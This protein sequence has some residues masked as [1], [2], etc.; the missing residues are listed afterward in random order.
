MRAMG[1][2]L[3]RQLRARPLAVCALCFLGGVVLAQASRLSFRTALAA[4]AA[5]FG[6]TRLLRPPMRRSVSATLLVGIALL[7]GILRAQ[8]AMDAVPRVYTQYNK[9]MVGRV[10]SEPFTHPTSGRVISKFR[11]ETLGG[12]PSKLCVRL[13]LRGDEAPL[14][15][16]AYG[17]RLSLTGHIW[18]NDP[19][20]NPHEFDFGAF[21]RRDGM[22]AMATAKIEDV[23]VVET[24]VD[25]QTHVIAARDALSRRIDALFPAH[26]PL[27][28]A[29]LLGDR[30][31]LS[32]EQREAFRD[33]GTAHLISISGLHVTVLAGALAALLGLFMNRR[34]A[35]VAAAV[36]LVPYGAVIGFPPAFV[37]AL[38]MFGVY[39]LAPV[40]GLP[41]DGVTRLGAA[42]LATLLLRP[43][44]ATDAGFVLSYSAAAGLILLAPPLERLLRLDRLRERIPPR[45]RPWRQLH[46]RVPLAIGGVLVAS[47]AAQLAILPAVVAFFGVQ[48]LLALPFNLVCVPLC[49]MGYLLALAAMVL[50]FAAMPV[51]RAAAQAAGALFGPMLSVTRLS[52][53]LPLATVRVGRYPALLALLHGAIAVAASDL[54]LLKPRLRRALPLALVL[55]AGLSSLVAFARNWNFRIVFLDADQADCAV[56]TTRGHTWLVDAGDTYSPA[57]DYLSAT[58]L[59]LDGVFLSHPHQDH[60]GGLMDVLT[61]FTPKAVYVPA[62]WFGAEGVPD[63]V[64]EGIGLARERGI[65]IVEL[66]AGDE[67]A[68]SDE[69]VLRVYNPAPGAVV[70]DVNDLST[71]ALISVRGHGALFT[72]DLT[73]DGE[74]RQLPDADVLKVAHHGADNATSARFLR[75]TTPEI[76]VV[77][78]GENSFGHPAR[79]TLER[80]EAVG[81]RT[82][83]TRDC[84]AVTL[85]LCRDEW[86]VK[87]F[88]EA[89]R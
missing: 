43:L 71:L 7:A 50:S 39:S 75:A 36:L 73:A 61:A 53:Q 76:A 9:P 57:A 74:P 67:I 88:L 45:A 63:A 18:A 68:L 62:G 55:V 19:V 23:A 16:I 32:E 22:A 15:D 65:E 10:V 51:A 3:A 58:A 66:A 17:Q 52:A 12:A 86:Q 85:R 31:Q 29:L 13:Y 89:S 35:S 56:V 80:L 20:T 26:A 8:L 5:F 21:L 44:A 77:S 30:S 49:L 42:L 72:G 41:S 83:L 70:E 4:F 54:S 14:S 2:F 64:T 6:A 59:S 69:A 79:E 28:R 37:R 40:V 46:L 87:T 24:V 81:A 48:P 47:L 82:L 1:R 60:A 84:G 25:L 38:I 78:V 33:T 27:V 11:L 34:A